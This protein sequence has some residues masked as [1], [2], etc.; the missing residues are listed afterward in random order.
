MC[1]FKSV[2]WNHL[3]DFLNGLPGLTLE[4]ASICQDL[5]GGIC[6]SNKI[7]GD[8]DAEAVLG[9]HF[10]NHWSTTV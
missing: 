2:C 7:P 6:I 4:S 3:E 9:T 8:A 1:G 5:G 10:E